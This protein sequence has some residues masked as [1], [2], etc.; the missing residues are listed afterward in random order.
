MLKK[1]INCYSQA[2]LLA[3]REQLETEYAEIAAKKLSLNM[4]RGKPAGSL[5]DN[6]VGVL[7]K[8]DAYIAQDGTDGRN[9]GILEG[10]PEMRAF[11][12][13]VL[14]LDPERIIVGGN[15]SLNLMYDAISRWFVFGM[16][17]FP[18]W[19]TLKEV[20]FLCPSPGYDRHFAITQEFGIQMITVPMTANG[21]DMDMVE[22]LVAND[23]AIKGIW[24]VP[25]YS[26]PQ[27]ICYSDETV[28][29]LGKMKCAAP[30]FRIFWDNAYGVHHLYGETKLA[31]I[32]AA[33]EAGGNPDR[34][35]YFFSTSKI[36]F[37]GA[38]VAM[39]AA[40]LS[41]RKEIL[42]RMGIQTIGSDKLNQLRTLKFLKDAPTLKAHMA[43]LADILRPKFDIVLNTLEKELGDYGFAT[44]N[45][46]KG[47]YFVSLDTMPNCAKATLLLAKE[48]GVAMTGAGAT[49]P[50]GKDPA[51]SNIRIAPTFPTNEDLQLAMNLFCVCVK[52]AACRYLCEKK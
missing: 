5:L 16:G 20:K 13:E 24:C 47:G 14:N 17:G 3:L 30:D 1:N 48:A 49:F 21:P 28:A 15:S 31:D 6:N 52:L 37:P 11:F 40:S 33:C 43:K 12:G 7:D 32:F 35:Y 23:P 38:G 36:T 29:R 50:Y 9:Y 8:L 46:P 19:R 44:W 34:A 45:A 39:M 42:K 2:E 26:N 27:G 25:L 10:L 18:A 22:E 41:E 4:A 51:D